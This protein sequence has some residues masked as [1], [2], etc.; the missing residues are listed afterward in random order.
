MLIFNAVQEWDSALIKLKDLENAALLDLDQKISEALA[1]NSNA[2]LLLNVRSCARVQ[3]VF[4]CSTQSAQCYSPV[5]TS[6]LRPRH[7]YSSTCLRCTSRRTAA[8][9]R[10]LQWHG[11]KKVDDWNLE[12]KPSVSVKKVITT[13]YCVIFPMVVDFSDRK[14]STLAMSCPKFQAFE[15]KSCLL[16]VLLTVHQIITSRA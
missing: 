5:C 1:K 14:P 2:L 11:E 8:F 6:Q 9:R 16:Q 15:S 10:R 13:V 12:W 7:C 3:L 4:N